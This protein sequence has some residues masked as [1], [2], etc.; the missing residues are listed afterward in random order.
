MKKTIDARGLQCPLPVI[1]T[2][3]VLKELTDGMVEIFVDNEIAVQ[4]LTKMAKQMKLN[5]SSE[6]I[7]NDH[8]AVRIE[9]VDQA[10]EGVN[11]NSNSRENIQSNSSQDVTLV[12]TTDQCNPDTREESTIIVL[13]TDHM[14]E[15]N[16]QLGKTLMKGFIYALTELDKLPEK[17][18]LY[19][20]GAKLP[21]EGSDSLE[22]LKLLE[23]QGVEILTCG[24]CLNFYEISD[25]L[26][27]GSV[28]NMYAIAEIM[29]NASKII[30]P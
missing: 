14:G 3:K 20:G 7:A 6:K 17:V 21:V 18:I 9:I 5:Y 11:Q 22:D 4:N 10:K 19:N 30:K 2:K 27:V 25:K 16:E 28:T 8:Y 13:S 26:S 29:M 1:E 12:S 23:A 15:G 24:T